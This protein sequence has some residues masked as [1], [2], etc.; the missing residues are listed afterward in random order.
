MLT[1]IIIA[2]APCGPIDPAIVTI[3]DA[4]MCVFLAMA[5]LAGW[6]L[7]AAGPDENA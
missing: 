5:G 6:M 1:G 4:V 2:L 7:V 3:D